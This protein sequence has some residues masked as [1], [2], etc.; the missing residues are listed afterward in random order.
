M[1]TSGTV[2][3]AHERHSSQCTLAAQFSAHTSG[4]VLSALESGTDLILSAHESGTDLSAHERH[5]EG[6][7]P[8]LSPW[9]IHRLAFCQSARTPADCG[10]DTTPPLLEMVPQ[11]MTCTSYKLEL[12]L[13]SVPCLDTSRTIFYPQGP[14][15]EPNEQCCSFGGD[16]CSYTHAI[17]LCIGS[18]YLPE[19][20]A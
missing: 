12:Q 2:L 11:P 3:S 19:M 18:W 1:H 16:F 15:S 8:P 9:I 20:V 13:L 17:R 10:I 14:G 5:A 4:T 6:P 7:S